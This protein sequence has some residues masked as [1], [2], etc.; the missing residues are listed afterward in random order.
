MISSSG[1]VR[2][3]EGMPEAV[4][5]FCSAQGLPPPTIYWLRDGEELRNSS[6]VTIL[7]N[8][9]GDTANSTLTLEQVGSSDNGT[10]QCIARNPEGEISKD[11]ELIVLSK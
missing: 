7:N 3:T 4:Q 6:L 5:L 9:F 11:I 10:H 1:V 8:A 2:V